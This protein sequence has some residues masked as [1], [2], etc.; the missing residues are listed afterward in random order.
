MRARIAV[1]AI[2]TLWLTWVLSIAVS[3]IG[4][5]MFASLAADRDQEFSTWCPHPE[6]DSMFGRVE[7][8]QWPL[9]AGCV[10]DDGTFEPT[11]GLTIALTATLALT[12]AVSH[13]TVRALRQ[14]R[15]EA[16]AGAARRTDT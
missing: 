15:S 2:R 3:G 5:L 4:L 14:P 13:R 9:D 11:W 1:W 12:L 7:V 10:Y 16:A 8:S 6:R